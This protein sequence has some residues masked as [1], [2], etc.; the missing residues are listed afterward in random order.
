MGWMAGPL[1]MPYD[2][3]KGG[4]NGNAASKTAGQHAAAA[5]A[6]RKNPLPAGVPLGEGIIP[7]NKRPTTGSA[8]D[9]SAPAPKT[10]PGSVRGD[11]AA[12]SAVNCDI[13]HFW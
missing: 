2:H 5:C 6:C 4:S 1:L 13:G 9:E 8:R 12:E 7:D 3:S 10:K 11:S